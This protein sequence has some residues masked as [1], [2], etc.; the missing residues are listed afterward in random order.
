MFYHLWSQGCYPLKMAKSR[1]QGVRPQ[2]SSND[3]F[4][5]TDPERLAWTVLMDDNSA[6]VRVA[7]KTSYPFTSPEDESVFLESYN[8]FAHGQAAQLAVI[9][10][11]AV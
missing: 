9:N 2:N 8:K 10:S 3:L 6:A 5:S 4:E 1:K 11:H 7:K